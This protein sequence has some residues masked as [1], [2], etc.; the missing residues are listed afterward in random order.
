M[1]EKKVEKPSLVKRTIVYFK[2]LTKKENTKVF[3]YYIN[4]KL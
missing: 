2:K 1:Q 3:F 4:K